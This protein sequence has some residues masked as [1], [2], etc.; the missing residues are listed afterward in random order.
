MTGS[1]RLGIL[2]LLLL[3]ARGQLGL[4]GTSSSGVEAHGRTRLLAARR[5]LLAHLEEP[6][7]RRGCNL[8]IGRPQARVLV[9]AR[10]WR[11]REPAIGGQRGRDEELGLGGGRA[12]ALE[13][14]LVMMVV[15]AAGVEV[16]RADDDR[17]WW[18]VSLGAQLVHG[19]PRLGLEWEGGVHAFA[20]TRARVV[21]GE[22]LRISPLLGEF[23]RR[24]VGIG[25][26]RVAGARLLL[27]VVV[28]SVVERKAG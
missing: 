20:G 12:G 1:G 2:G 25:R 27:V 15:G 3:A 14:E 18:L 19:H 4:K 28:V 23:S 16:G 24:R 11:A 7:W 26:R 17:G 13:G 22:R 8:G 6:A 5:L 21:G 9:G 10:G